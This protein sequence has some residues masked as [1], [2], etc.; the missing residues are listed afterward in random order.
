MQDER[1]KM[2]CI[3]KKPAFRIYKNKGTDKLI[4]AFIFAREIVQSLR[5]LNPQASIHFCGCIAHFVSDLVWHPKDRFS[6]DVAQISNVGL[7]SG[8]ISIVTPNLSLI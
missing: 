6:Y 1:T 5:F 8:L 2:S 7:N 4:S 3:M